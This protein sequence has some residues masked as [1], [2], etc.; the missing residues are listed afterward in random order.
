MTDTYRSTY[1]KRIA[2][3]APDENDEQMPSLIHIWQSDGRPMSGDIGRG[4]A[5]SSVNFAGSVLSGTIHKQSTK[6]PLLAIDFESDKHFVQAAGGTNDYS[7]TVSERAGLSNRQ[8]F[9][10]F[11]FG[12][13]ARKNINQYLD[14]LEMSDIQKVEGKVRVEEYPK[15]LNKCLKFAEALVATIKG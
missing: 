2:A 3:S 14:E 4:A 9:G 15:T 1:L 8:G 6:E 12:G 5:H 11:A 10:G 13:H 7:A